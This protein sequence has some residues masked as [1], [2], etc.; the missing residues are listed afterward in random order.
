MLDLR[1]SS[2]MSALT[3]L[4]LLAYVTAH[5]QDSDRNS[6]PPCLY[7]VWCWECVIF[8]LIWF[9]CKKSQIELLM[10]LELDY[11]IMISNALW[12]FFK[13]LSMWYRQY[14]KCQSEQFNPSLPDL[15][16]AQKRLISALIRYHMY[17]F[18]TL[19]YVSWVWPIFPCSRSPLFAC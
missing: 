9:I 13:P 1:L 11:S 8:Y 18:C 12:C 4:C 2:F 19:I 14:I 3:P 15:T 17:N 16:S 5:T 6:L 10:T 7:C